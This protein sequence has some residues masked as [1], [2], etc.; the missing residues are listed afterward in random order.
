MEIVQARE[1]SGGAEC[2]REME[3]FMVRL[4]AWEWKVRSG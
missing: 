1:K 3:E 2:S 4:Q